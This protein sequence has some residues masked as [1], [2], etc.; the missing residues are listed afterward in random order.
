MDLAPPPPPLGSGGVPRIP[1]LT[2]EESRAVALQ[3]ALEMELPSLEQIVTT[4]V[5][6]LVPELMAVDSGTQ[7]THSQHELLREELYPKY[8]E[9][10]EG[11]LNE[12]L[13]KHDASAEE[14]Y[15]LARTAAE[16]GQPW[17]CA[18]YLGAAD[19][20]NNFLVLVQGVAK[21]ATE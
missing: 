17:P 12:L 20:F 16:R 18:E 1:S 7:Y 5:Q 21:V 3:R 10:L 14:L 2:A 9:Q 8:I 13:A 6:P 4:L 11:S 19:D 15:E